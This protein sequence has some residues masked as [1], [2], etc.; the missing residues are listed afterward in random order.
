MS[1]S[2]R[3]ALRSLRKRRRNVKRSAATASRLHGHT[4]GATKFATAL[5]RCSSTVLNSIKKL[6]VGHFQT[7]PW[8]SNQPWPSWPPS[9]R[10]MRG[11]SSVQ[12]SQVLGPLEERSF[13]KPKKPL[14]PAYPK[15]GWLGC[16][17]HLRY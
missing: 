11:D 1:E 4:A 16:T 8:G 5:G 9:K 14:A 3:S 12:L 6:G 2:Q 10:P 17:K 13:F 7:K 15:W